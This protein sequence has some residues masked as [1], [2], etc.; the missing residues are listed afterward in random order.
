MYNDLKY[1]LLI[2]YC[3]MCIFTSEFTSHFNYQIYIYIH[4]KRL[5]KYLYN[6]ITYS[7]KISYMGVTTDIYIYI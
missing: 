2:I 5:R 4:V 1:L 6:C 7:R 3:I